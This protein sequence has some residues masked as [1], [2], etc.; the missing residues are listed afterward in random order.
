[1][2][3]PPGSIRSQ[4]GF[5]NAAGEVVG[6]Y[7]DGSQKRHGFIWRK[8]VFTSFNVPGDHTPLGTVP[9]GINESGQ[10]VGSYVDAEGNRHG[11]LRSSEGTFTTLDAPGSDGLTVAEGI[12]NS[13]AIVGLYFDVNGN[14]HGF[15]LSKGVYTT[16]D[17]PGAV[18]TQINSI[19]AKGE[20]V[21]IY[22]DADGISHG[23]FG[24]PK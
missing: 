3:N 4:A 20:I 24:D 23:F 14:S 2:L 21:G 9:Q 16:V 17:V 6:A 1:V 5:I 18:D 15:V 22:F 11:F 13:G 7:R 8:G 19:N 12:N 10:I